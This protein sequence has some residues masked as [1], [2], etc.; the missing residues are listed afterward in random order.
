LQKYFALR[1]SWKVISSAYEVRL[2]IDH[3]VVESHVESLF[4]TLG[5]EH[6]G[7]S[8]VDE[9]FDHGHVTAS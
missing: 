4:P 7:D 9:S 3:Q 2:V 6:D 5:S 1:Q 8:R